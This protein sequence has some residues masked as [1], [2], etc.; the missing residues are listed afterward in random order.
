MALAT[1]TGGKQLRSDAAGPFNRW[2]AAFRAR[3]GRDISVTSANRTRAEQQRLWDGWQRRLPGFNLAA[4]PGTSLH[5][6]GLSVDLASPGG[7]PLTAEHKAWL[8][9]TAAAYGFKPTGDGFTPRERWHYDYV[10]GGNPGTPAISDTVRRVQQ[11]LKTRYPLYA[12]R[13][14]VD[15]IDGPATRAAVKEYQRRAGLAADGIIGPKTL[16]SLG[17]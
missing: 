16:R 1:I 8:N 17:L 3:F 11:A 6:K 14:V 9:A 15:G 2:A 10:G 7:V 12:G 5:E 13:L 4:R